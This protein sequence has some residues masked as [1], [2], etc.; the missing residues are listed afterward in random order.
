MEEWQ[1]SEVRKFQAEY[2]AVPP[3]WVI[4]QDEHPY[5]ICWRMGAGQSHVMM[6]SAWWEGQNY[7][8]AQ[9]IAYFQKWP[10]PPCW[11]EWMIDAIWDLR[12]WES[13]DDFDYTPYFARVESLG[14]GSKEDFESDMNDPKWL[15]G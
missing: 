5:S 12:P 9:R 4:F 2:G 15:V 6:W 8:E 11:L 3:P 7:D 14:F 10:P 1:Q 13:E